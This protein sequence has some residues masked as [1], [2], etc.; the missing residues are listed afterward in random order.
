[1]VHIQRIKNHNQNSPCQETT[2]VWVL[3]ERVKSNKRSPHRRADR[4]PAG[5]PDREN[6]RNEA[7]PHCSASF[8]TWGLKAPWTWPRLPLIH[9]QLG[10]ADPD[11]TP[12]PAASIGKG[13]S[14]LLQK[15]L[16]WPTLG[17]AGRPRRAGHS[18]WPYFCC[19]SSVC[20]T[21]GPPRSPETAVNVSQD[22]ARAVPTD[23]FRK[24]LCREKSK[25]LKPFCLPPLS[26]KLSSWSDN[27]Y[28]PFLTWSGLCSQ[29]RN[30]ILVSKA[31]ST[32]IFFNKPVWTSSVLWG[33]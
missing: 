31:E 8:F 33:K 14:L 25:K 29:L 24:G 9:P 1:M 22:S 6:R 5:P 7:G 32:S 12:S 2:G 11:H 30:N 23:L 19:P 20:F 26:W 15:V 28:C 3:S 10:S 17:T 27:K 21:L 18:L 13:H 4:S 16:L